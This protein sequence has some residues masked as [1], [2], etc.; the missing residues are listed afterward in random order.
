MAS[1]AGSAPRV[2]FSAVVK[3]GLTAE[4]ADSGSGE[5]QAHMSENERRTTLA[6]FIGS[7][8][9]EAKPI[10]HPAVPVDSLYGRLFL[11]S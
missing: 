6:V 11:L 5:P 1:S 4:L 9:V 10:L 3:T 2:C 7:F 8:L